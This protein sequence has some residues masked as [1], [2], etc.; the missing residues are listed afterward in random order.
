MGRT[1][2]IG[3]QILDL[4]EVEDGQAKK[5]LS[6]T[7]L[8]TLLAELPV[9]SIRSSLQRLR[10]GD[11]NAKQ[12]RVVSYLTQAGHGGNYLPIFELG[13]EPDVPREEQY[14]ENND[15]MIRRAKRI[16]VLQEER[17][18]KKELADWF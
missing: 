5:R 8:Y 3:A 1:A 6:L 2:T 16:R 12:I 4:F 10:G 17:A 18:M 7:Q 14:V 13:S 11:G 15:E 9:T